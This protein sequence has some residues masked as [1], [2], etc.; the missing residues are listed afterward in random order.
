MEKNLHAAE[1]RCVLFGVHSACSGRRG[2]TNLQREGAIAAFAA[3]LLYSTIKYFTGKR[4]KSRVVGRLNSAA[5]GLVFT[6]AREA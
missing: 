3:E 5:Q 6:G 1:H 4:A 2:E